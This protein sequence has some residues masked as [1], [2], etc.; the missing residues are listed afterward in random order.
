MGDKAQDTALREWTANGPHWVAY[1][2]T[3]HTILAPVTEA[4][5]ED[6]G[7]SSGQSVLDIA[8]GAGEPSLTIAQ[9][10]GSAG[11]VVCTDAVA[12][13]VDE[14]RRRARSLGLTNIEFRQALADALPF[15]DGQFDVV[16]CRLGIMFFP[17]PQVALSEMLRVVKSGGRVSLV[18]W[19]KSDLNPFCNVITKVMVNHIESPPPD[20]NA[21]GAFRFA[22]PGK[23]AGLMT[24]AGAVDVKERNF[25]FEMSAAL[26]FEDFW[27]LRSHASATLREQLAKLGSDET[28][29]VISEVKELSSK[30]FV[31]GRM[32]F[33][34][35]ML[36][37]T[38]T[39][40]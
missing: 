14:S 23:L 34:T 38:G 32:N 12:E 21:P 1:S 36:I 40:P 2:E 39:K 28:S 5:I 15:R 17:D 25:E 8:G 18:V 31:G 7:I 6:A 20:S 26:N 10:V 35:T 11:A 3:L 30:Y 19:N 16:V 13:M 33:P 29:T 22:E 4:L 27:D 37:V 9:A 24:D